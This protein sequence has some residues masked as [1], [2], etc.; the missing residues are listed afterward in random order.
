MIY[1]H[2]FLTVKAFLK[3]GIFLTMEGLNSDSQ[4][5]VSVINTYMYILFWC[6]FISLLYTFF[7]CTCINQMN[8][9]PKNLFKLGKY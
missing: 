8:T 4:V 7:D 3:S 1:D 5:F 2:D 6:F 9:R